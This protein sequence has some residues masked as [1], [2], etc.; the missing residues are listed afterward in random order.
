M[1]TFPKSKVVKLLAATVMKHKSISEHFLHLRV[2][3]YVCLPC[4]SD[5]NDTYLSECIICF[6]EQRSVAMVPCGH[7]CLCV[8][9]RTNRCHD[10][11]SYVT[12]L[13]LIIIAT[14]IDTNM[15]SALQCA[16]SLQQKNRPCP[17]CRSESTSAI[18]I[19]Q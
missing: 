16:D 15:F 18:Q 1:Q 6:E 9:V 14:D 7:L 8:K 12:C 2:S 4:P 3:V 17:V 11:C 13:W 19:F 10:S 5:L